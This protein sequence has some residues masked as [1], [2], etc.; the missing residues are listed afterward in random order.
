MKMPIKH[1]SVGPFGHNYFT[2]CEGQNSEWGKKTTY[3]FCLSDTH[4]QTYTNKPFSLYT[5]YTSLPEMQTIV[6][7]VGV[8]CA[9]EESRGH[10]LVETVYVLCK[11]YK[12]D[13]FLLLCFICSTLRITFL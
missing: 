1:I 5:F 6:S 8:Q 3:L 9:A 13:E 7:C 12:E 2:L 10:E 4:I 11:R